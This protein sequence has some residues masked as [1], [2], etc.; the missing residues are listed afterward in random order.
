MLG[1]GY[2][3]ADQQKFNQDVDQLLVNGVFGHDF[4]LLKHSAFNVYRVNLISAQSGVTQKV[5][6]EHGTPYDPSDDTVVS[7][8]NLDT[9]LKFIW[10]GSWAHCWLE[11]SSDTDDIM[12]QVLRTYVPTYRYVLVILN[13]DAYG[14]CGG[15]G[16]QV[17]PRQVTWDVIA[18]EYGH[19]IG[20]LMDEYFNPNT[21]YQGP[22]VNGPNVSTMV[23]RNSVSWHDLIQPNTSV[24]TTLGAGMDPNTTVGEFQGGGTVE[25]GVYRPVF[26][27]RM[28]SNLPPYCPVCTRIMSGIID[29][30]LDQG[31][32]SPPSATS[33]QLAAAGV[34]MLTAPALRSH[35]KQTGSGSPTTVLTMQHGGA[36]A[37][38]PTP[39]A[40]GGGQPTGESYLQLVLRV[41]Q[42]GKATVIDAIELPGKAIVS[43][44]KAGNW[45]CEVT[46]QGNAPVII[47]TLP[48][49]FEGRSFQAPPTSKSPQGFPEG[50]HE[51]ERKTAT[52]VLRIPNTTLAK[53][54]A[55][56]YAL[57]CFSI[58]PGPQPVHSL[59]A[60]TMATLRQADRLHTS[61][62]QIKLGAELQKVGRKLDAR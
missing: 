8:T 2:S 41:D 26:D 46:K 20:G 4:Y 36:T 29:P 10:S 58:R 54:I 11:R 45:V 28:R 22:P 51:N 5:Y 16:Q 49:P 24:P 1:D 12:D 31:G 56:D 34:H 52:I 53:A 38:P 15:G 35:V 57:Q 55:D 59:T 7:Q 18:H 37:P 13:Q 23:D 30:F 27:C 14:G 21:I 40:A 48:N 32:H 61:V 50:H 39:A 33:S 6:D 42:N 19:G 9:A 17:V 3:A 47:R 62:P 43:D 60:Q 25:Q 44:V